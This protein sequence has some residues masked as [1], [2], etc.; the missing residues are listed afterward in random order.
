ML[1]NRNQSKV[2]AYISL[3][4]VYQD[5]L[6]GLP[7]HETYVLFT[8]QNCLGNYSSFH[9]LKKNQRTKTNKTFYSGLLINEIFGSDRSPRRGDLVC[10][11]VRASV[12]LCVHASVRP[13]V[14]HF[15]QKNIEKEF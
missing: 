6:G 13:C 12:R 15:H 1:E 2:T 10:A 9:R 11:S 8:K 5:V 4:Y 7:H 14:R 3:H